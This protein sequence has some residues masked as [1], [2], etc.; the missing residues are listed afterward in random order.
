[1][2]DYVIVRAGSAGCVLAARLSEHSSTTV[3]LLEAGPPDR[4]LELKI[5]AAFTPGEAEAVEMHGRVLSLRIG[6]VASIAAA[7]AAGH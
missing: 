3:A 6:Q 5:P 4:K 1:M 2:H 7:A